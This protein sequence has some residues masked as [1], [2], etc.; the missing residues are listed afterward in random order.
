MADV[1]F[2]G[3]R[4][5]ARLAL[6]AAI[7]LS[8]LEVIDAAHR[9]L[10]F[11]VGSMAFVCATMDIDNKGRPGSRFLSEICWHTYFLVDPLALKAAMGSDFAEFARGD[12]KG[13]VHGRCAY[14]GNAHVL[15]FVRIGAASGIISGL[16]LRGFAVAM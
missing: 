5:I 14:L 12:L 15:S 9:S 13:S 4:R 7:V 1:E 6:D 2:I 3:V 10:D 8:D 16:R 11:P